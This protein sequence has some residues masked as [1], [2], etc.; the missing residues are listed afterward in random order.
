MAKGQIKQKLTTEVKQ[1]LSYA[2]GMGCAIAEACIHAGIS[3]TTYYRWCKEDTALRDRFSKQKQRQVLRARVVIADALND[4]DLPTA[5]WYLERKRSKE[6]ST[7]VNQ[8]VEAN[9]KATVDV[10]APEIIKAIDDLM[11][12]L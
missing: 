9:V 10:T 12:K 6:F 11:D 7:T 4:G 2:F 5:K 8:E 1:D 3:E